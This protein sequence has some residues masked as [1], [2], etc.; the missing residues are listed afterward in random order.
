MRQFD[1]IGQVAQW[2]D[3]DRLL[4]TDPDLPAALAARSVEVIR[5]TDL[6]RVAQ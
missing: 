3:A 5:Y 6:G 2:R 4:L 1:G